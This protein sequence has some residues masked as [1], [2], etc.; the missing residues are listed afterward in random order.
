MVRRYATAS[1]WSKKVA[2]AS[3]HSTR[4]T[5]KPTR[6]RDRISSA[7]VSRRRCSTAIFLGA[8]RQRSVSSRPFGPA[9]T[10]AR[11]NAKCRQ[12]GPA[13]GRLFRPRRSYT[14]VEGGEEEA[15][16][17]RK[18][19]FRPVHVVR[20]G[21]REDALPPAPGLHHAPRRVA[22]CLGEREGQHE[23]AVVADEPEGAKA[24]GSGV[25]GEKGNAA[26]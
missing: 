21:G 12:G 19:V 10:R 11:S 18:E 16:D 22:F 15:A 24:D 13:W 25:A 4:R 2:A 1:I 20:V 23:Q 14:G 26:R 5:R 9:P 7:F 3:A 8:S 6:K 17:V